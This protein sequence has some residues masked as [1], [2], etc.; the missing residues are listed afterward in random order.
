[1]IN[2]GMV[3]LGLLVGHNSGI[4]IRFVNL[5]IYMVGTIG[6]FFILLQLK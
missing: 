3:I 6:V 1:M 5:I 4:V 2:M